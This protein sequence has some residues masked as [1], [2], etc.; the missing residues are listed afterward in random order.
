MEK[1]NR[2]IQ[3]NYRIKSIY[4]KKRKFE[5]R[6]FYSFNFSSRFF[7]RPIHERTHIEKWEKLF[8]IPWRGN[9]QNYKS[10]PL[11]MWMVPSIT[12]TIAIEFII[13]CC[14][15]SVSHSLI[16]LCM[17][18][19]SYELFWLFFFFFKNSTPHKWFIFVHHS[20]K[21]HHCSHCFFFI[22]LSPP[23]LL[24]RLLAHFWIC[25][26]LMD[27]TTATKI[28]CSKN[29]LQPIWCYKVPFIPLRTLPGM[30]K[31]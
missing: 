6:N 11:F 7:F 28:K 21:S 8:I 31:V 17:M 20:E 25:L 12:A 5:F 24:L 19:Y 23:P 22:L 10:N 3:H 4:K 16:E 13:S 18:C 9:R 26:M 30:E 1:K 2:S 27:L 15:N 29:I 14:A